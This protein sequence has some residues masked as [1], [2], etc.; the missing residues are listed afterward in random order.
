MQMFRKLGKLYCSV[1]VQ[2]I[3]S[4]FKMT[5]TIDFVKFFVPFN[6]MQSATAPRILRVTPLTSSSRTVSL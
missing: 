2:T 6:L 1:P 3:H 5:F 4:V